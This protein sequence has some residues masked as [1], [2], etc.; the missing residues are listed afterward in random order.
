MFSSLTALTYE[1]TAVENISVL[2]D[3]SRSRKT[4]L[5]DLATF[6][7]QI[8]K[9]MGWSNGIV[10]SEH[11]KYIPDDN[12]YN[13]ILLSEIF[14]RELCY[15]KRAIEFISFICGRYKEE[16]DELEGTND[17]DYVETLPQTVSD[18]QPSSLNKLSQQLMV[19]SNL[20]NT[21]LNTYLKR[22]GESELSFNLIRDRF[23][24]SIE[25]LDTTA[26]SPTHGQL[27]SD[28][29][30]LYSISNH[31]WTIM[32]LLAS[33]NLF[34]LSSGSVYEFEPVVPNGSIFYKRKTF[35]I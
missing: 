23:S 31:A 7:R 25:S 35:E 26:P 8:H 2:V 21:R 4:I 29:Q 28:F 18:I 3:K 5:A 27:Q 20:L 22:F 19:G 11:L 14:Y 24:K 16:E 10:S 34:R 32:T 6:S 17:W 1:T 30:E 12:A 9:T 13:C 15:C 33:F